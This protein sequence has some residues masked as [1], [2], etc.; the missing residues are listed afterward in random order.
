M[1]GEAEVS[2]FVQPREEMAEGRLHDGLKL[3]RQGSI[4]AG[5][6][7]CSLWT[8]GMAWNWDTGG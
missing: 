2:W 3:P 6:D 5:A 1:L 7:L 4:G 8:E